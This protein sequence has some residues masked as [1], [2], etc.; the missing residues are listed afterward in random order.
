MIQVQLATGMR[1]GEVVIMRGMDL[2]TSGPVWMYRPGSERPEG[3]HK[4]AWRGHRRVIAVGPRGQEIVKR[5]LKPELEAYLFSPREAIERLRLE[6]RAKRKTKVQPSQRNRSKACPR[7]HPGN[8]YS[9]NA[10]RHAI[11]RACGRANVPVWKP[12]QLRHSKATEIRREAG[13]DAARAVLGHR[14]PQVTETYAELDA[15]KAAEVMQ[16][17]G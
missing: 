5:F 4:T 17:L 15:G 10:Y 7:R 6:R 3:K 1:P 14:S 2:E 12:H 16:R 8:R 13:L 9:V 11:A